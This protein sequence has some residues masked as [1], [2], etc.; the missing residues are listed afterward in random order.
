MLV[1]TFLANLYNAIHQRGII[2]IT[3][4]SNF[5]PVSVT[6]DSM[7]TNLVVALLIQT[8][9]S[10]LNKL[11]ADLKALERNGFQF[12]MAGRDFPTYVTV[13]VSD[14]GMKAKSVLEQDNNTIGYLTF[15]RLVLD[16]GGNILLMSEIVPRQISEW[17]GWVSQVMTEYG[18]QLKPLLILHSSIARII[19][20]ESMTNEER[21]HLVEL[22]D[23]CNKDFH[24]SPLEVHTESVFVGTLHDLYKSLN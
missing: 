20:A 22:V 16:P 6:V 14:K 11:W 9:D 2:E 3:S 17:R 5:S 19:R 13:Q 8:D 15:N 24:S 7:Q 1:P 21:K 10:R 12:S 23:T 4:R 18:G